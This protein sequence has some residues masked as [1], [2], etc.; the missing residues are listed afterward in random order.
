[1][2]AEKIEYLLEPADLVHFQTVFEKRFGSLKARAFTLLLLGCV[3]LFSFMIWVFSTTRQYNE[4]LQLF[5]VSF[6][7]FS[8]YCCY[9]F[10]YIPAAIQIQSKRLYASGVDYCSPRTAEFFPGVLRISRK[11][12]RDTYH[13][14]DFYACADT[15]THFCFFYS[16]EE[17]SGEVIPKSVFTQQQSEQ[18]SSDMAE[19]F[20]DRYFKF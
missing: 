2:N 18:I 3:S 5:I 8:I 11:F 19:F 13:L 17:P 14:K 12:T 7:F 16:A 1:M 4:L 10:L 9:T 20:G 15:L 6:I